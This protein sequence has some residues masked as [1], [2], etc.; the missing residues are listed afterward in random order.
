MISQPQ[1]TKPFLAKI[2]FHSSG[3][4]I[5][6][7]PRCIVWMDGVSKIRGVKDDRHGTWSTGYQKSFLFLIDVYLACM[8]KS[9]V[10]FI[11]HPLQPTNYATIPFS[12]L[13]L[14]RILHGIPR[15][16]YREQSYMYT[17]CESVQDDVY[18]TFVFVPKYTKP[19]FLFFFFFFSFSF[20]RGCTRFTGRNTSER[21][22]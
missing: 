21:P 3:S 5:S 20:F 18:H 16:R 2:S 10:Y 1:P 19:V 13:C 15:R 11:F 4:S 12:F 17:L 6:G 9:W 8:Y 14:H 22:A 7:S